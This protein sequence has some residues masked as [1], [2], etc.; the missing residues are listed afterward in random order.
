MLLRRSALGIGAA[1]LAA[2]LAAPAWAFPD[3]TINLAVGFS[4]GGST[5]ITSRLLADRLG[6]ALGPNGRVIVENRPG[7][8]GIIAAD[9]L[10][11]QNPDGHVLML[12]EASSHAL[13]P[14]AIVG[15]TRY[16]PVADYTH[17]A[18]VGSGPMIVVAQPNLPVASP[19]EMVAR[20]RGGQPEQ[21][22]FA[23]SGVASMPHLSGEMFVNVMGMGGR[24]PHIAYRSGGQMVE[25]IAKAETQWGV[26][27]LASAAGQVRDGRVRGIAVTGMQRFPSFPDIPTLNET[28]LPGFDLENWFAVI[29]PKDMPQPVVAQLNAAIRD[30]LGQAQLRE[31]LLTAGVAPW[32]R[33]NS[34][35]DVT[36]FFQ[37]EVAKFRDVVART[38]VKLEP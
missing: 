35:A 26:A 1:L 5:D 18:M 27:V 17:I 8:A 9:W 24:F 28:A 30:A 7:A 22:P 32:T 11:R 12:V 16:D 2:G 33:P 3:R 13:A 37:A 15:G 31:R 20:M 10:R 25:S 38:G 29:G 6:P 14:A 36:A 4:P 23:S 34:P 21:M 19:Q